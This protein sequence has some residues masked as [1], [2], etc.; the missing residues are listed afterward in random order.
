M[1]PSNRVVYGLRL[2]GSGHAFDLFGIVRALQEFA[3][4][5]LPVRILGFPAFLPTRCNT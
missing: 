3:E 5:G 1:R 2:T 4:E